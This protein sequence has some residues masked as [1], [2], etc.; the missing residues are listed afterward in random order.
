MAGIET[1][2]SRQL[3]EAVRLIVVRCRLT[4]RFDEVP[5]R[6]VAVANR[7]VFSCKNFVLED[8]SIRKGKRTH[9]LSRTSHRRRTP[10]ASAYNL[11]RRT[12]F[13]QP[14]R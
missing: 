7:S 10:S 5:N 11:A 6:L 1:R 4:V 8:S 13:S 9:Q 14:T 3:R 12:A 2:E